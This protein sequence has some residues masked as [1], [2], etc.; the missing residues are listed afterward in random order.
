MPD[1]VIS[2][3]LATA[4]MFQPLQAQEQKPAP[5]PF[6]FPNATIVEFGEWPLEKADPLAVEAMFRHEIERM[7]VRFGDELDFVCLGYSYGQPTGAFFDRLADADIPLKGR[8]ACSPYQSSDAISAL[9]GL[10]TIRCGK[11]VCTASTDIS[12]GDTIERGVP[13]SAHKTQ[14]GWAVRLQERE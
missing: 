9:V 3:A 4:M 14:H 10:S 12:F 13:I 8:L 11:L 5:T 7:K 2:S 1:A 6:T